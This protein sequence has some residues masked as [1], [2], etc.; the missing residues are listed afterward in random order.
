MCTRFQRFTSD[1]AQT[2]TLCNHE[3][4]KLIRNKQVALARWED[5]LNKMLNRN[6]SRVTSNGSESSET[7]LINTSSEVFLAVHIMKNKKSAGL[8]GILAFWL[9]MSGEWT[10][11][12][13]L[14][15]LQRNKPSH[16]STYNVCIH[17]DQCSH[18]ARS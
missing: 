14:Q 7:F 1:Y 10:T 12:T 2:M 3:N 15:K 17:H 6:E 5:F 13:E 4:G 11:S 8:D 16:Y 9:E 18:I